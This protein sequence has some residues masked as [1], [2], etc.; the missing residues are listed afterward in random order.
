MKTSSTTFHPTEFMILSAKACLAAEAWLETIEPV[1]NGIQQAVLLELRPR[2][3]QTKEVIT[4]PKRAWM[5]AENDFKDYEALLH[6]KYINE[7]FRVEFGYCPLLMAEEGLRKAKLRLATSMEKTTGLNP[8]KL[9][10]GKN[11]IQLFD[12]YVELTLRLLT[13]Y[14]KNTSI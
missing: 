5:M 8:Q 3:N 11:G 10:C 9:L 6:Q 2:D 4:S 7:G 12:E 14:I 13:P 1:I